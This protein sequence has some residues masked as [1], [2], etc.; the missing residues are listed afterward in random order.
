MYPLP[1]SPAEPG[2]PQ[3]H[4]Y[5]AILLADHESPV[6]PLGDV[7][8]DLRFSGWIAP[9]QPGWVML[10][11]D[12]G[13]GV[14]AA[15]RRGI[16]EVAAELALLVG[17]P[18]LAIRVRRDRQLGIVAWDEGQELGRYCSD[19]SIEITADR[20]VLAEPCGAA[21]AVTFARACGR[22]GAADELTRT[23]DEKLVHLSTFESERLATVLRLLD[24]PKWIVAVGALPRSVPTG[25]SAKEFDRL[26][27]GRA[28][29]GGRFLNWFARR[30]RRRHPPPPVIADPPRD[31]SL[32][33]EAWMF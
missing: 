20:K 27:W 17:G 22:A 1:G 16:I 7:L 15:G 9:P 28:G 11:G 13:D 6:P 29:V 25:P 8:R 3:G 10:F 30:W 21:Y 31:L 5:G 24:L 2:G 14:V 23:L 18:V 26:R 19:P 12:P 33:V 4:S 32:D